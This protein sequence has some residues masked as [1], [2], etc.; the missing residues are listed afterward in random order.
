MSEAKSWGT[1]LKELGIKVGKGVEKGTGFVVDNIEKG[2]GYVKDSMEK[3]V[4]DDNLRHRFNLENPYKFEVYGK[5][6]KSTMVTSLL[7]RNA[8]RYEEDD[9]FVFFGSVADNGFEKGG[10]IKDLAINAEFRILDIVQVLVPVEF[11]GKTYEV[12]GT[13]LNCQAL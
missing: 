3:T 11:N 12:V 8:K 13:A 1:K 2:V 10:I 4:L 6:N 9:L 7:V 5:G